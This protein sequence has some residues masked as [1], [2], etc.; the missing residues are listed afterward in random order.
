MMF[1]EEI[2]VFMAE[3]LQGFTN[4]LDF[5]TEESKK[6]IA[7]LKHKNDEIQEH[8]HSMQASRAHSQMHDQDSHH[9][10]DHK[11]NHHH[12]SQLNVNQRSQHNHG[13]QHNVGHKSQHN[14]GSQRHH[15]QN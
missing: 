14:Q 11:S 9:N 7:E 8:S 6:K 5:C 4:K 2:K 13:S 15:D 3:N 10:V 1:V 12:G